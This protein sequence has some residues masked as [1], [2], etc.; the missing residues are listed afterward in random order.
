M[1]STSDEI[2]DAIRQ[3]VD[4]SFIDE[5][6]ATGMHQFYKEFFDYGEYGYNIGINMFFNLEQAG[7]V[8]CCKD[9]LFLDVTP[10]D[11]CNML[12]KVINASYKSR[13]P[14]CFTKCIND[15]AEIEKFIQESHDRARNQ[16]DFMLQKMI[17]YHMQTLKSI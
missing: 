14:V 5:Y 15:D 4:E 2:N 13:N 3:K 1:K 10:C 16:I 9:S 11:K 17:S 7:V 6:P 12:F 8:N